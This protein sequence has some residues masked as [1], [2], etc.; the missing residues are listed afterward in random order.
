MHCS[1]LLWLILLE[2]GSAF[3]AQC[4]A[5]SIN[6]VLWCLGINVS[7]LVGTGRKCQ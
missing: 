2:F 7:L 3:S 5:H 6:I 4:T 1:V